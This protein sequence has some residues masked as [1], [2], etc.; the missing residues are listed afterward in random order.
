MVTGD[1]PLA[2][3]AGYSKDL[4]TLTSGRAN[5]SMQLS[6]YQVRSAGKHKQI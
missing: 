3:L 2:E 5:I 6:H 1:V 4:R